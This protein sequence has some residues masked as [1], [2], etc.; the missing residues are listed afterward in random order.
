MKFNK[1]VPYVLRTAARAIPALGLAFASCNPEEPEPV[2]PEKVYTICFEDKSAQGSETSVELIESGKYSKIYIETKG[3][4]LGTF[5]SWFC[6][7]MDGFSERSKKM[8]DGPIIEGRAPINGLTMRSKADSLA[9]KAYGFGN[10]AN[11]MNSDGSYGP[12]E[13]PEAYRHLFETSRDQ[14]KTIQEMVTSMMHQ[15]TKK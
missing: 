12:A 8:V 3:H 5:S 4:M 2:K 11:F 6:E 1:K 14:K 15:R 13:M 9:L 10:M 7:T